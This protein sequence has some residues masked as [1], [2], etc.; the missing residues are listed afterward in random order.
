[1]PRL[2][3]PLKRV[4][5]PGEHHSLAL[6]DEGEVYAFGRGDSNQLGLGD[7]ADQH[8]TPVKIDGLGGVRIRKVTSGSNQNFAVAKS[9]DLYSWGFGGAAR[10]RRR[11]GGTAALPRPPGTQGFC[12]GCSTHSREAC[13][14]LG[15][16]R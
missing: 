4:H 8:V 5:S 7:G 14:P 13:L 1:M 3:T 11:L 15:P 10:P 12:L 6:T 2:T 9:G 16:Q